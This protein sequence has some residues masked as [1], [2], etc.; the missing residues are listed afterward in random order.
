MVNER[1]LLIEDDA[2][3]ARL[4]D[5]AFAAAGFVVHRVP[6]GEQGLDYLDA[7]LVAGVVLDYRLPLA[8]GLQILR[9]I[10]ERR[11]TIPIV[12]ISSA[13][14][15]DLAVQ[16]IKADAFDFVEK[17]HDYLPVLV[18][19][20][21]DALAES[22]R[23]GPRRVA[24]A[25]CVGRDAERRMLADELGR[26]V[27]S[28][29]RVVLVAG[30]DGM[31]K[32]SLAREAERL[33]R[34][35][36]AL[37]LWGRCHET[38]GAPAYWPWTQI[39]RGYE[40]VVGPDRLDEELGTA[41]RLVAR[42]RIGE[43]ASAAVPGPEQVRFQLLDGVAQ[44]LRRAALVRP[45]VL[46]LDDLHHADGGS[47]QLL[48]FLAA[49]IR[50]AA[51]LL[52]G[53]HREGGVAAPMHVELARIGEDPFTTVVHLTGFAE[54]EVREYIVA[55]TGVHPTDALV[56][57]V[58]AKTEG[59]P[60]FVAE[61]VRLLAADGRLA[62][63]P[64]SQRVRLAIPETRRHA[65][66]DRLARVSVACRRV[67]GT[68]AVIG[69]EFDL[70]LLAQVV[71]DADVSSR[72][73]EEAVEAMLVVAGDDA[74]G[75]CRFSHVL[76]RDVLYEELPPAE[77]TRLHGRIARAL[78]TVASPA[79]DPPL[80]AIA[81][82]CLQAAAGSEDVL[83]AVE[84]AV[85]AGDRAAALMAHE[86]AARHYEQALR[87]VERARSVPCG[88]VGTVLAKLADARWRAG[89]IPEASAACRR[90]MRLAMDGNVAS[91]FATAALTFAG[92]LPG[93]GAIV[94]DE[95]VVAELERALTGLPPTATALRA[96]LMARLA[97]ELTY[98]PRRTAER[99]VAPKA[100]TLARTLDDPA[101]LATV[102]R[103]TQWSVWTPDDVERRRQLAEEIV[104]LA[105]QTQDPV[106]ALDGELLRLWS[107]L[108]H[109]EMD[110]A[111]RQLAVTSRLAE[112]L[113]LP[114]YAWITTTARACLHIATGRLDD[115]ESVADEALRAGDPATNP[116]VP[117]FVGAQRGHI[118][119]H[120][121]RFDE[122][123]RWLA[124]VL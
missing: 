93:L 109:G 98:S 1:L 105:A 34:E 4:I 119:W 76:V 43:V 96:M 27:A 29:G 50:D 25:V 97:E 81:H 36:G 82:H 10:R 102:L 114:Y 9:R 107:A 52:V 30:D 69:R 86:E 79:A 118:M 35:A 71:G 46:V 59:H 51:V 54:A 80:A 115:A 91:A 68:A 95:E 11:I 89:E 117:L 101:V 56:R 92:R 31:G 19:K 67:L 58:H 24:R 103:T 57:A 90:L 77:R 75:T 21:R 28:E 53:T 37:V 5:H 94:S 8:D 66:G 61:V 42:P 122:L 6:T 38:G 72:S 12:M 100:I 73:L 121:G 48:R 33:A 112:R 49:G 26:A 63:D 84:Y 39:L 85:L 111:R 87:A 41:A 120:R 106:L 64:G 17:H 78:E 123:A 110:A 74:P 13:G 16:A 14:S 62:E 3:A 7:H 2:D 15:I 20:M 70:D 60:L 32:T 83:T 23:R 104:T 113:R 88:L 65:I 108:E 45:L 44:C 116:T 40:K 124:G 22:H 47:I 99:A 55:A 18:G